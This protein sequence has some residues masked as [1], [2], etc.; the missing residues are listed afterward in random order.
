MI[1]FLYFVRCELEEMHKIFFIYIIKISILNLLK[2]LYFTF[3]FLK[4][5]KLNSFALLSI[6]YYQSVLIFSQILKDNL[7]VLFTKVINLVPVSYII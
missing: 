7:F 6:K 3:S 1:S 2:L 4:V 5:E